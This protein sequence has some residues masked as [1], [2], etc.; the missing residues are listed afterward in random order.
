MKNVTIKE[1]N[2]RSKNKLIVSNSNQNL[3]VSQEEKPS[4]SMTYVN[5]KDNK[6]N[7]PNPLNVLKILTSKCST[8]WVFLLKPKTN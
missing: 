1:T 8:K 2:L 7:S 5:S 6:L 3:S 4:L